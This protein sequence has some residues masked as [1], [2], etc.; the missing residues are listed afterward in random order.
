MVISGVVEPN[1]KA[2]YGRGFRSRKIKEGMYAI[3]FDLP[4]QECPAAACIVYGP[5]WLT[6]NQSTELLDLNQRE[7]CVCTSTSE[8]LLDCG[9]SFTV[10]GDP[11]PA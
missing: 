1:G 6:F 5:P 4:F 10:T 9:F 3:S 11:Q 7:M 8:R 2:R